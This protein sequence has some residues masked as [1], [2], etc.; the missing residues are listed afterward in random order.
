MVKD[1]VL[2]DLLDV[3]VADLGWVLARRTQM[4]AA[5]DSEIDLGVSKIF[6]LIV[7]EQKY[8]AVSYTSTHLCAVSA[9][10]I[11]TYDFFVEIDASYDF[12]ARDR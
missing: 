10:F 2:E 6:G 5:V 8:G 9:L 7:G 4:L 1:R 3:L 11:A 12:F